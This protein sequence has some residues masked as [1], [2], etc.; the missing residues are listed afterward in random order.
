MRL[1]LSEA[2]AARPRASGAPIAIYIARRDSMISD[3]AQAQLA[4]LLGARTLDT[5]SVHMEANCAG[6][7][8]LIKQIAAAAAQQRRQRRQQRAHNWR[9]G[10]GSATVAA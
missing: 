6:V 1:W 2:E 8:E 10:G 9:P 5:N 4:Q 3:S 7:E